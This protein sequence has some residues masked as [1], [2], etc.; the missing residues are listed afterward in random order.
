[1]DPDRIAPAE[2]SLRHGT[3]AARAALA[4]TQLV[5]DAMPMAIVLWDVHGTVLAWNSDAERLYGWTA[6]D[7][8]GRHLGDLIVPAQSDAV[9][10]IALGVEAGRGWSG[11]ITIQRRDG[12]P[13]RIHTTLRPLRDEH[14]E[15][16]GSIGTGDDVTDQRAVEERAAELTNHLLMALASGELGTW[17]RDLVTGE[18]MWDE[19]MERLY[20]IEPGTYDGTVDMWF[21][22]LH[23]GDRERTSAIIDAAIESGSGYEVEYRVI[24]PSDGS[25]RWLQ[26]R[27]LVTRG[28]DGVAT[29][30]IGCSG[31]VTDRKLVE[32]ENA[33]R[34]AEAERLVEEGKLHRRRLEFLAGLNDAAM[35]ATDHREVMR[36]VTAAAVPALGDWCSLHFYEGAAGGAN[37][38][39]ILAHHDPDRV[40]WIHDLLVRHPFD[41][42]AP[43]G[44]AAAIRNGE[45]QFIS[46]FDGLFREQVIE[47]AVRASP[48]QARAILDELRPTSLIAV[49]LVTK[50]GVIG[51]IQFVSAESGRHYDSDDV[52]LAEA[53]AGRVAEA[54]DGAWLRDQQRNIATVLQSALLPARLP[55]LEGVSVAVRYWA[56]GAASEVGGDF[57]D[58]F[59]IPDS[60]DGHERWA[61][62]IGDVC[63][64]GPEAAAVTALA[65]HTIRAAARHGAGPVEVLEWLNEAV[66]GSDTDRFCTVLSCTLER[67]DARTWRFTSVAGGHPLPYLVRSGQEAVA[68][69]GA[70]TLIGVMP[71]LRLT[72]HVV[73][74]E[75]G[76]TLVLNTDGIT[77]VP[78]PY[79]IDEEAMARIVTDAAAC[80]GAAEQVAEHL[81]REVQRVLPIPLR[82]DDIALVVVRIT[83]DEVVDITDAAEVE[84]LVPTVLG[85]QEFDPEPASVSAARDF[86]VSNAASP[87]F[88]DSLRLVVSELATNAVIHARS[89]F[90]VRVS[91]RGSGIRV[92]VHDGSEHLPTWE[93]RP[94]DA[95]SGRGMS[96]VDHL[97][98]RWG[99]MPT[100][101]G[102][103]VWFE[104]QG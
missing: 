14:G 50:R 33:R 38:E 94:N 77:D 35:A 73:D 60:A 10:E 39:I 100:P 2:P 67:L 34:A 74:L 13:A 44:A 11:D 16:V 99:V 81:G 79:G 21:T 104:L 26:G 103:A 95:V 43:I 18:I 47:G 28:P 8:L 51:A 15:I 40:A 58:V 36:A 48:T 27:A 30:T 6:E 49:P 86:V 9:R 7:V 42:E 62:V 91:S 5:L 31:D 69:G 64:T 93:R 41:P 102:K 83:G 3:D 84:E 23:P 45:T 56:A 96:I 17:R 97:S 25:V 22:F 78:D 98:S 82:D 87:T 29:A 63:G 70:G 72:P 19:S 101:A 89:R 53:A 92:E 4:R 59:R 54:L 32:L 12:T 24:R 90:R 80:P 68:L 65:R 20:G 85:E 57:Y 55:E 88:D 71:V 52:A 46:S 1:V 61:I 37:P 76:D 66:L 75:V